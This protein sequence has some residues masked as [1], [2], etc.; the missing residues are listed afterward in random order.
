M[1]GPLGRFGGGSEGRQGRGYSDGEQAVNSSISESVILG[2]FLG[3]SCEFFGTFYA[4]GA[5]PGTSK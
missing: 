5:G 3:Y 4:I 1:G 2:Y